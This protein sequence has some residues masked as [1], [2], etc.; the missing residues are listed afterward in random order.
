MKKRIIATLLLVAL[1]STLFAA[2]GKKNTT[3]ST[4]EAQKI[5]L[6]ELGMTAAEVDDIHV[7]A[8]Q[9]DGKPCYQM[10]I[11]AGDSTYYVYIDQTGKVLATQK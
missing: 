10:H 2:C 4:E 1:S 5:A 3:I 9:H 8:T 6:K 7:H 11:T